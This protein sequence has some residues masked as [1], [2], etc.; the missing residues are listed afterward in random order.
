MIIYKVVQNSFSSLSTSTFQLVDKKEA[1]GICRYF[2]G[3]VANLTMLKNS[4][5][6]PNNFLVLFQPPSIIWL[7]S[8]PHLLRLVCS[9]KGYLGA[10][11]D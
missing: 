1:S 9:N 11:N 10:I 3:Q 6:I 5:L 7:I 4:N 2:E 8:H